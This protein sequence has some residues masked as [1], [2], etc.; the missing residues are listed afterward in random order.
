M[1]RSRN[2]PDTTKIGLSGAKSP[3]SLWNFVSSVLAYPYILS[4][5]ITYMLVPLPFVQN[6]IGPI[7]REIDSPTL[8]PKA[9][10]RTVMTQLIRPF[11]TDA[12]EI[13]FAGQILAWIDIAAGVAAKRHTNRFCV[14]A[15]VDAVH[16]FAP[17]KLGDTCTVKATVNRVWKTSMEVGV[18]VEAEDMRTG[19]RRYCCHAYLTF[20]ALK[21]AEALQIPPV[22]VQ[23]SDERRRFHDANVRREE[24]VARRAAVPTPAVI[25]P[26]ERK[27]SPMT[28]IPSPSR[29]ILALDD[30]SPLKPLARQVTCSET[31]TE[32]VE[33]VFPEHANS[34]GISFGG[35]IMRWMEYCAAI[36]ANRL[37]RT[38]VLIASIDSLTFLSPTRVGDIVTIRGIVSATFDHSIEIYVTVETEHHGERMITNDGWLTAVSVNADGELLRVKQVLPESQQEIDRQRAAAVRRERRLQERNAMHT[39]VPSETQ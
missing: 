6:R 4:L 35:Q 10:T 34:L 17:V 39:S 24:R 21:N 33:I 27:E 2:V 25:A 15:S 29:R 22:L 18:K 30:S 16:F 23:T 13:V 12:R 1:P 7:L 31:Y 20:V 38:H 9:P 36:A 11:H 8:A 5:R 3:N 32:V 19:K 28:P 14:T 26:Y 37:C